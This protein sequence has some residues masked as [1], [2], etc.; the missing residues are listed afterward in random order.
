MAPAS[1]PSAPTG[2]WGVD[3][4]IHSQIDNNF[5]I[6]AQNGTQPGRGVT[7]QLCLGSDLQRWALPKFDNSTNIVVDYIGLCMDARLTNATNGFARLVQYCG[8]G[9]GSRFTVLQT[10]QVQSVKNLKCL[11]IPG[12]ASN[13]VVSLATCDDTKLGQ[14][15]SFGH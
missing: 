11:S 7:L 5:C 12:A 13:A 3:F 8:S 2:I 1:N 14:L 6:E 15:W 4:R 10:G 9:D